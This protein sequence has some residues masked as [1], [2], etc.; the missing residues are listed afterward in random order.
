MWCCGRVARRTRGR[1]GH[2]NLFYNVPLSARCK[3]YFHALLI[4]LRCLL[5]RQLCG[6]FAI[7]FDVVK[8]TGYTAHAFGNDEGA[9]SSQV[10]TCIAR[11]PHLVL[12]IS[13]STLRLPSA[14]SRFFAH[15]RF[16]IPALCIASLFHRFNIPLLSPLPRPAMASAKTPPLSSTAS[17]RK[18]R[19]H[20]CL[21]ACLAWLSDGCRGCEPF[22]PKSC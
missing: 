1:F 9:Y 5:T 12:T 4:F 10:R 17:T 8:P 21:L 2:S 14:R 19:A 13:S 3:L 18:F 20:A 7:L 22:A 6:Q 16:H 15:P 11:L